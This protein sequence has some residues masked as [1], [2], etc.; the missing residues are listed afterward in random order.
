[1]QRRREGKGDCIKNHSDTRESVKEE[2]RG[3]RGGK[4]KE[5]I[6]IMEPL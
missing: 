5:E 4:M 3:K 6:Y 1:M 2:G